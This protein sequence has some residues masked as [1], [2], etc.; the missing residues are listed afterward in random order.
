MPKTDTITPYF[1]RLVGSDGVSLSM[2]VSPI[3]ATGQ[4]RGEPFI[5]HAA[6][7]GSAL[8]GPDGNVIAAPVPQEIAD[9]SISSGGAQIGAAIATLDAAGKLDNYY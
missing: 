5:L 9:A 4:K 3:G 8:T 6:L 1:T 7:D 2:L